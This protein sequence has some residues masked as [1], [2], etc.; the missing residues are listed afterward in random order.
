M[1][2]AVYCLTA[3]PAVR[4]ALRPALRPFSPRFFPSAAAFLA[5]GPRAG[6]AVI[7]A[8]LPDMSGQDLAAALRAAPQTAALLLVVTGAR[9]GAPAP[10]AAYLDGGADEYFPFPPDPGLLRAR[11]ANLLARGRGRPAAERAPEEYSFGRLTVSPAARTAAVGG[12][13]VR[14]TALEFDMLLFFLRNQGRVV[15]RGSLLEKVWKPGAE[16]GPRAVDKRI[17]ALR[18]KLGP[19]GSKIH[20]VFGIGYIFRL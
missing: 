18:S 11:V 3:D 9:P 12:R 6:L 16:A 4:A 2:P 13:R 17:E 14:L 15:A 20:T 10:A 19:F 1:K 5:A 7:D 8:A